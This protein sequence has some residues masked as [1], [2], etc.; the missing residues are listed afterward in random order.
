MQYLKI[1]CT[2]CG[3]V[4]FAT[5][6][7]CAVCGALLPSDAA[8]DDA[9]PPLARRFSQLILGSFTAFGVL[10]GIAYLQGLPSKG[11]PFTMQLAEPPL[12]AA[13]PA[14]S[15][16]KKIPYEVTETWTL[17]DGGQGKCILISPAY[18]RKKWLRLL[19]QQLSREAS[20]A[21]FTHIE[22]FDNRK[23]AQLHATRLYGATAA[24]ERLERKYHVGQYIENQN[25]QLCALTAYVDGFGS[26]N[27]ETYRY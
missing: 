7:I 27:R 1:R 21:N 24:Q 9:P 11:H 13:A 3:Q 15:G 5:G 10:L 2:H 4:N 18:A 8:Y 14:P 17:P 12:L 26:V 23:A 22:V 6:E 16:V 19:G 20:L 25:T